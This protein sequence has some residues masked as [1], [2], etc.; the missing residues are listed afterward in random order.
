MNPRRLRRPVFLRPVTVHP[1]PHVCR[2]RLFRRGHRALP[3][4]VARAP[5]L[6]PIIPLCAPNQRNREAPGIAPNGGYRLSSGIRRKLQ[7][8]TGAQRL[9]I[10]DRRFRAPGNLPTAQGDHGVVRG[11]KR[12][13]PETCPGVTHGLLESP[14][15]LAAGDRGRVAAG[16]APPVARLIPPKG[17]RAGD[18]G[19]SMARLLAKP[20]GVVAGCSTTNDSLPEHALNARIGLQAL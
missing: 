9:R 17:V 4:I 12:P 1:A 8:V 5:E 14:F 7:S 20:G 19:G 18:A 13:G 2:W 15:V 16:R 11:E 6:M 10:P 3:I